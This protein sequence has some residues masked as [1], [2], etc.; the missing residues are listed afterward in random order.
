MRKIK[1]MIQEFHPIVWSLVV[2]TVFVRA[3]SSMSMPFLFLY[4]SNNTDLDL[5]TIGMMIGAGALAGTVGGFIA[6]TLSDRIGRRRVMIGALYVWT[7]VFIGFAVTKNPLL[8]LLF[9]MAGGLCRSFY[10]P[11]SQA[12]MADVTPQEKRYRVFG[13]RYTAINVG[14]AVGPIAGAV[15]AKSSVALPFLCTAV[16]YLIYVISLQ[17]LLNRFGIKTIEGQKKEHVTFGH[18]FRVVVH[19]KAFRFYMIAGVLGAIGYSQMS[20]TLAKYVELSI[21]N[22]VELF[23]ILMSVNAIV[24]VLLQMPLTTWAEKRTPL[25]AIVVGNIMYAL[26]DLGFAFAA[27][28]W[29]FIIAMILFTFGEILTFTSGDVL[30]D[31][32][33]PEAMRGSYYGAKSFSNLGQFIGPWLGGLLLATYDGT[34]LF[35]VVA[36]FSLVSSVFHWA[37]QRAYLLSTGKSINYTR[38]ESL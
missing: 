23:A 24:V 33:A 32:M 22:G 13:L 1:D 5:A 27:T 11:V 26:G 37:G 25:T 12:L 36:A 15:L 7:L 18:A 4:L 28:G 31:R 10:E 29:I 14:V 34:V 9:N 20:T 19:D 17:G 3:A 35:L 2:G 8:L 30:I 16:I 21:P 6:G 38:T